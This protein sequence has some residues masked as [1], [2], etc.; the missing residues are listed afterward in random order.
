MEDCGLRK[1]K[2]MTFCLAKTL[3]PKTLTVSGER[4]ITI[5]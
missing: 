3:S 2:R 4:K 1:G 5:S